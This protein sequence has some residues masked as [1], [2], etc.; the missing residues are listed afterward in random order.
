VILEIKPRR[1]GKEFIKQDFECGKIASTH[2]IRISRF[3]RYEFFSDIFQFVRQF[4]KVKKNRKHARPTNKPRRKDRN[5]LQI[6]K[7]PFQIKRK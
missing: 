1:F 6:P 2:I 5:F 4:P 7:I 3:Y